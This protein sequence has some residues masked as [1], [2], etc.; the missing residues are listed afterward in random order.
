M[1]TIASLPR[2]WGGRAAAVVL[3]TIAASA[4]GSGVAEAGVLSDNLPALPAGTALAVQQAEPFL[5]AP[6]A[7]ASSLPADPNPALIEAIRS[8]SAEMGVR[9][10][11]TVSVLRAALSPEV[12]GNLVLV[13]NDMLGCHRITKAHMAAIAPA[14]LKAAAKEYGNGGGLNPSDFN[15]IRRCAGALWTSTNYLEKALSKAVLGPGPDLDVWPVVRYSRATSDTTYPNDYALLIDAGGNDTY[16]NNAGANLIDVNWGPPGQPGLKGEGPAR[17]CARAIPGLTNRDCIPSVGVLLDQAGND[18]YGIK[19][20]PT[21]DADGVGDANCTN[22]PLVRR[23]VTNGSGFLGVGIAIDRS[24]NDVYMGKTVA[25]GSGHVFGVGV[26]HDKAGD[27]RYYEVRNGTGFGL[28]GG[29]GVFRDYLGNDTHD[30]YVPSQKTPG[31]ANQTPGAGG[32]IDDEDACDNQPRYNV[33]GGNVGATGVALDD[34]GNDSYTGGFTAL[35]IAPFGASTGGGAS[36]GYANN[37]GAAVLMDRAGADTYQTMSLSADTAKNDGS[38]AR[39]PHAQSRGNG[40]TLL[41][42]IDPATQQGGETGTGGVFR[43]F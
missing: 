21:V 9:R 16:I 33:G 41:P 35:F 31:A 14:V 7:P 32:A 19:Q 3:T 13:L 29:L 17:G 30:F 37:Q 22:E 10:D 40:V 1:S 12:A 4:L 36:Q 2:L 39:T 20:T 27:D 38:W 26:L 28:V 24:G 6:V 11:P 23:M 42:T 34:A 15:D 5:E 43:D 8:L 18:R 25:N